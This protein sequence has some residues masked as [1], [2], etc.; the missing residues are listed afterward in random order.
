MTTLV[1]QLEGLFS[2]TVVELRRKIKSGE[3]TAADLSAAIKFL[4]DND[5]TADADNSDEMK[6]LASAID[7][8]F[9]VDDD[10]VTPLKKSQ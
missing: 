4:K 1:E 10:N 5:I 8:E 3:A 7:D 6:S 2:E 9:G